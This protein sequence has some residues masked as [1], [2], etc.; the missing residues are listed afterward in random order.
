LGTIGGLCEAVSGPGLA[1]HAFV[2]DKDVEAVVVVIVEK[3]DA[4]SV[5]D[6]PTVCV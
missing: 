3:V 1:S 4:Q 2:L 6:I 5:F